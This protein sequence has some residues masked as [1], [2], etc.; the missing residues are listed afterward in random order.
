MPGGV[1]RRLLFVQADRR[2]PVLDEYA[3]FDRR[4]GGKR[5][6]SRRSTSV[7]STSKA[8]TT[9]PPALGSLTC[10]TACRMSAAP[11]DS[12]TWTQ[13]ASPSSRAASSTPWSI[14]A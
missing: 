14:A 1:R 2:R 5:A 4:D 13:T 12:M 6:G 11:A 10:S 9:T 3:G 7:P 8:I